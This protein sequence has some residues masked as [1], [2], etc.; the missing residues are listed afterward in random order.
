MTV[1]QELRLFKTSENGELLTELAKGY[2]VENGSLHPWN[3]GTGLIFPRKITDED[4][5]I[6]EL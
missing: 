6:T 1:K 2:V 4:D 5:N 3:D